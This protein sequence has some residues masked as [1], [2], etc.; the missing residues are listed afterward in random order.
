MFLLKNKE[1]NED[2]PIIYGRNAVKELILS[3]K[4]INKVYLQKGLREL[5]EIKKIA[6]DKKIIVVDS[7]KFKLDKLAEGGTHQGIIASY[8]EYTYYDVEDILEYSK[9]KN[10]N[11]FIIILDKIEDPHNLGAIIR[12]AECM[13]VHGIIIA[14]RNACAI[15]DTVEKVAAGA[16]S[17][18][19]VARVANITETLKKLK[20]EGIWVYGLDMDGETEIYNYDLGGPIAIVVGNEGEG[21]SRLVKE[22][23]DAILKIPMRGTINSLNASVSVGMTIYE[24]SRQNAT[25]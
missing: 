1:R 13:G 23:C 16:C 3:E 4:T 24:V 6:L 20:K 10:E 15:T 7:D 17:Y 18:M 14:K 12:T 25:K 11:P 22:N 21:I 2:M 8:T 9:S 5:G 19:R